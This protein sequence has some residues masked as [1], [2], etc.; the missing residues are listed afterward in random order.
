[1]LQQ[2]GNQIVDGRFCNALVIIQDEAERLGHLVQVIEQVA[3]QLVGRRQPVGA[4]EGLGA[5]VDFVKDLLNRSK[6]IAQKLAQIIIVLIQRYPRAGIVTGCNPATGQSALAVAS[7]SRDQ[8]QRPFASLVESFDQAVPRH[9]VRR[10][11]WSI[12]LGV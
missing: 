1:M 5:Q 11:R 10:H 4:Q 2:C 6:Q 8:G 12:K 7:R 3:C 9:D